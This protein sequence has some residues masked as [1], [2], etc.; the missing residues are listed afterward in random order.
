MLREKHKAY[1]SMF[2]MMIWPLWH[3]QKS[4][5]FL[6]VLTDNKPLSQFTHVMEEKN[7]AQLLS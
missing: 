4:R 6:I 3:E 7:Q 5:V 2:A 1:G